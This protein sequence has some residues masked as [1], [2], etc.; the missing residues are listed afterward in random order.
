LV[1][2]RSYTIET[3]KLS[4]RYNDYWALKDI[5]LTINSNVFVLMGPNG[6]G[7]TTLVRILSTQ[8]L[9]TEGL[10]YVLGYDV[11]K[12]ANKI[13]K[14][15]AVLPQEARPIP[16]ATPW[17]HVY[18]YLIARGYGF[19]TAKQETNKILEELGL[20]DV[21]KKAT[22]YLSA[23]LRRRTILA[24]ILATHSD[25]CFLDEPTLGLDPTS[26]LTTWNYIIKLSKRGE[27][28]FITTNYSN[29]A[30][31]LGENIALL[32]K[33]KLIAY[34][35]IDKLKKLIPFKL[36]ITIGVQYEKLPNN[37]K[38]LDLEYKIIARGES[39][40]IYLKE[41]NLDQIISLLPPNYNFSVAEIS[42]ED[43]FILKMSEG[44]EL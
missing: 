37:I 13:R 24:A 21:R 23:G 12:E 29:E 25:L 6:A 26:R 11:I 30:E 28:F 31:S 19:S 15:I 32:N 17:E 5:D 35:S 34:G 14:R 4:K 44:A 3:V 18:F 22:I 38:N 39:S 42:L 36:K 8:L 27:K 16:E 9:P 7:K 43:I 40:I 1:M 20:W 2:K 41:K 10:A 33:G